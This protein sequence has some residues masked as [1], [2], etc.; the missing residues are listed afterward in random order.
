[1]SNI[2]VLLLSLVLG[3]NGSN[4]GGDSGVDADQDGYAVPQDCN[5][6]DATVHPGATETC[7]GIDDNCDGTVDEGVQ[8]TQYTD[9]DLDGFGDDATA[10]T[11]CSLAAG[12]S[13]TGG[14]CDDAKASI[15]PDATEVCDGVDND[16]DKLIDAAD[17][18]DADLVTAYTDADGDGFGDDATQ[19]MACPG[20][21]VSKGGDCN[22]G[23]GAINP[24]ATEVCDGVDNDCDKLI[25]AADDSDADLV[26]S[27][28]D[29]DGDG[30]GNDATETM[31]CPGTG[32]SKGGDCNDGNGAI[33][34]G[35]DEICGNTV[36]E[37]CSG[38]LD[39]GCVTCGD[40]NLIEYYDSFSSP[41][42]FEAGAKLVGATVSAN[43]DE[44]SFDAAF[45]RGTWDMLVID[46]PG[47]S[48]PSG[49]ESRLTSFIGDGG[50]VLFSWWELQDDA[51][52]QST[53]GVKVSTY[54]STPLSIQSSSAG[55]LWTSPESLPDPM[56][57]YVDAAG[58][59]GQY[60][61]A[62]DSSTSST[63]ATYVDDPSYPAILATLDSQIL[64]H[65]F[66]P[67]DWKTTDDD[68]DGTNDMAELYAN[69]IVWMTDCSP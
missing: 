8:I 34:P 42:P 53:L 28:T 55:S 64:F 24:D 6:S 10:S 20:T 29:A 11:S 13:E 49:V 58:I 61:S 2:T 16:C 9:A 43:G 67:W 5:D 4:S 38:T 54:Y 45:D 50:L 47:S 1:M 36:D 37:N 17:D 18:S 3:C 33:N 41:T 7:N 35:A 66:L 19:T 69:E 62:V 59:N 63:L 14:D 57:G 39:D 46:V 40:L 25:D 26:T 51:T 23:D 60:V 15:N 65:S 27:Y 32:V 56:T 22:D 31:A 44:S 21:G 68:L 30:F 12:H 52:L 48:L